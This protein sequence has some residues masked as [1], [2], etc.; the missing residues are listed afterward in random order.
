MPDKFVTEMKQSLYDRLTLHNI[1][2]VYC[3][4]IKWKLKTK[5]NKTIKERKNKKLF[6]KW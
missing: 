1:S 4:N 6:L 5:P 2:K 3:Q